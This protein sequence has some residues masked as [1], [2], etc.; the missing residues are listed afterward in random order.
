MIFCGEETELCH[1]QLNMEVTFPVTL[2]DH[3]SHV[4]SDFSFAS[5]LFIVANAL[6]LRSLPLS[7]VV[8]IAQ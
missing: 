3:L 1:I 2:V 7:D 8:E 4:L 6:P 5:F